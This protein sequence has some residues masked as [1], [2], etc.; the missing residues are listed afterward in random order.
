M[1]VSACSSIPCFVGCVGCGLPLALLASCSVSGCSG[2]GATTSSSVV[3]NSSLSV[4]VV[5]PFHMYCSSAGMSVVLHSSLICDT[6]SVCMLMACVVLYGSS[7]DVGGCPG[8][9]M[10]MKSVRLCC[11]RCLIHLVP[12]LSQ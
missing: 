8:P 4:K 7:V 6:S 3:S 2:G 12:L 5:V 1:C 10:G 11:R 9:S